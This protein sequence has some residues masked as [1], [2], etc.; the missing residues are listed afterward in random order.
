MTRVLAVLGLLAVVACAAEQN[1]SKAAKTESAA[2]NLARSGAAPR[3]NNPLN[4]VQR[5][6]Q[7]T[8]EEQERFIEK[9]NPQQQERLR[10][11]R[12]RYNGFSLAQKERLFRQYQLLTALPPAQQAL[13]SREIAFFNN[14]LPEDRRRPVGEELVRLHGMSESD[15][16][17]RLASDDFRAKFSPEEQRLLGNLSQNLPA[18]YP[19]YR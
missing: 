3:I 9:A 17:A 14:R 15:R 5:F 7:M 12:D 8:P 19:F 10:Q 2:P 18:E 4:P 13:I 16:A 1:K 11:A 6:L